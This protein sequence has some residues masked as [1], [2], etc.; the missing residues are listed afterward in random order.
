MQ[1]DVNNINAL[2]AYGRQQFGSE[3][4]PRRRRGGR[5]VLPCVDGLIA[6]FIVKPLG[7]VGREGSLTYFIQDLLEDTR[8]G[9]TNEFAALHIKII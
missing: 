9:K 5:T 4:Q 2:I 8:I 7:N 1:K 6:L 3:V